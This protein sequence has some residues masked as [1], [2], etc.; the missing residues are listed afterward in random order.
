MNKPDEFSRYVDGSFFLI[1]DA[2]LC[3]IAESIWIL[4]EYWFQWIITQPVAV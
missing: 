4:R 1:V 3:A 2:W